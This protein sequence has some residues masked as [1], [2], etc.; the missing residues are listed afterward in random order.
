MKARYIILLTLIFVF[1]AVPAFAETGAVVWQYS[2][3]QLYTGGVDVSAVVVYGDT[4][5]SYV[6]FY[7]G[8]STS[9]TKRIRI[10]CK[11]GQYIYYFP[12]IFRC[13]DGLY[14]ECSW[15]NSGTNNPWWGIQIK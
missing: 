6:D 7:D 10:D 15:T 8:T 1:M 4:D 12:L 13:A 14:G 11:Q 9:G 3:G 2:T 5:G